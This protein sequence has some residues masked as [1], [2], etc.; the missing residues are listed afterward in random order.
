MKN[1]ATVNL[2]I[3]SNAATA[4]QA[5]TAA[6]ANVM[7]LTLS[8]APQKDAPHIAGADFTQ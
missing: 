3:A 5:A 7:N 6:K 4:H 8:G 2:V 1:K